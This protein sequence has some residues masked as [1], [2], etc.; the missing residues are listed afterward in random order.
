MLLIIRHLSGSFFEF[1]AWFASEVR[2]YDHAGCRC[3]AM[4]LMMAAGGSKVNGCCV[5]V[6]KTDLLVLLGDA[7]LSINTAARHS[8]LVLAQ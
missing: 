1:P 3:E 7:R 6:A 8:T 5:D 2:A 4:I